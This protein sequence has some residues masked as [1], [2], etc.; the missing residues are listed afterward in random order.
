[1]KA[2]FIKVLDDF[3]G[4]AALYKLAP[5]LEGNEFVAV[6]CLGHAFDTWMPETYI[7]PAN[8]EGEVSNWGEL[9]G[10]G[11]GFCNA[12]EALKRAGYEVIDE[13]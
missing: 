12:E 5:P 8:A 10:S 9:T 2:E 1:M 6:P 11:R 7:F 4:Y 13:S 3:R